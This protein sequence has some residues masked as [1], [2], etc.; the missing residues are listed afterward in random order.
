MGAVACHAFILPRPT[1]TRNSGRA[2]Q[3]WVWLGATEGGV[4]GLCNQFMIPS[5]RKF[6]SSV[7]EAPPSSLLY[8]E[9]PVVVA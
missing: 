9:Y 4:R 8:T 2:E 1:Q 5:I 7:N 3:C 6:T